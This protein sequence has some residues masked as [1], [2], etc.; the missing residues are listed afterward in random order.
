MAGLFHV[1]APVSP[2]IRGIGSSQAG[3]ATD[4]AGNRIY[5]AH[6]SQKTFQRF[7]EVRQTFHIVYIYI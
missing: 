1:Q 2:P 3:G 6:T 5:P 4:G 7:I